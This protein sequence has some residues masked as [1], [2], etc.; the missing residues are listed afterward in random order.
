MNSRV[1]Y[2]FVFLTILFLTK[3]VSAQTTTHKHSPQEYIESHKDDAVREMLSSGVPASITLAQGM[4]ESDNGNSDL[5][6]TANN[7]FGIKCHE[8]WTG[9]T[10]IKDDDKK[11]ECF[12]KYETVL[13]SYSDHSQFLRSKKRYA[14]LFDLKTTDYK[15]WAK[16][17]KEAGYAT[18]PHYPQRLLGIIEK[19]KLYEYDQD[20]SLPAPS[21][22]SDAKAPMAESSKKTS[23]KVETIQDRQYIIARPGDS[24]ASLAK[25]YEKGTWELPKYNELDKNA[26]IIPGE[27]IYLQPKRRRGS[28]DYYVVKKGDT[29]HSISQ[30]YCIKLKFLYR[31]NNMKPGTEP[32]EGDVLS[33]RRRKKE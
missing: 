6:V 21:Y 2:Y 15:G 16:G 5:A 11:D 18:D 13:E 31:K 12:R 9:P 20:V 1:S 32:K 28:A 29:M 4:L 17:L 33:L 10:Y 3:E 23:R 22:S 8:D 7:H 25:E 27:R 30:E 19:N 14:F 26:K 24:F